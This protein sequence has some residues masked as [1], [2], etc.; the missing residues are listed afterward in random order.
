MQLDS[1]LVL[2]LRDKQ[3]SMVKFISTTAILGTV[4]IK[5]LTFT[6]KNTQHFNKLPTSFNSKAVTIKAIIKL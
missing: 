4:N 1:T 2:F 6:R 3:H 5:T